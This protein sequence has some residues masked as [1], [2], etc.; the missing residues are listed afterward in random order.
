MCRT[1]LAIVSK[2]RRE[3]DHETPYTPSSL[4]PLGRRGRARYHSGR[5][6]RRAHPALE[7]RV[8]A[9]RSW[10]QRGVLNRYQL[11]SYQEIPWLALTGTQSKWLRT[12]GGAVK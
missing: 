3:A 6:A 12:F 10:K 1:T 11:Q 7:L 8:G 2:A 9:T 4:R 5:C